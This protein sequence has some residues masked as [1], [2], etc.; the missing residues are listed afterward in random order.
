MSKQRSLT[1]AHQRPQNHPKTHLVFI[2]SSG[3]RLSLLSAAL[4][5]SNSKSI[6]FSTLI[7]RGR[8]AIHGSPPA[9][10]R[11]ASERPEHPGVPG[12]SRG[13]RDTELSPDPKGAEGG[14]ISEGLRPF[15]QLGLFSPLPR[16][17]APPFSAGPG[18]DS[19]VPPG[20]AARR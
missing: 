9:R 8:Q 6:L 4:N 13:L 12:V 5:D 2:L 17:S 16:P 11:A 19:A 7:Q 20:S 15:S 10:D 18:N 3:A 14:L 1:T